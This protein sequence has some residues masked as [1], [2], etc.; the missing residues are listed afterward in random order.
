MVYIYT[1]KLKSIYGLRMGSSGAQQLKKP[2]HKKTFVVPYIILS[3]F[4]IYSVSMIF[5]KSKLTLKT[6][7]IIITILSRCFP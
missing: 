7:T 2:F 5:F 4:R 3:Y 1:F 6:K